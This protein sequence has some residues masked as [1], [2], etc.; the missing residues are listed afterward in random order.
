MDI[1]TTAGSH[2]GI[3]LIFIKDSISPSGQGGLSGLTNL[4]ANLIAYY[5]RDIDSVATA[6]P[7]VSMTLGQYVS[8]G[9]KEVDATH[10][11]GFYQFCPPI[12]VMA[13]GSQSCCIELQGAANMIPKTIEVKLTQVNLDLPLNVQLLDMQASIAALGRF[14]LVQDTDF[15]KF[16]FY[17]ALS[18]DGVSPATGLTITAQREIDGVLGNFKNSAIESAIEGWYLID[19]DRT[20]MQGV[21]II[22]D[23]SGPGANN[24]RL[25]VFPQQK[26]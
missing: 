3:W 2:P 4:S 23:F 24:C 15:Y 9:F 5:H 14:S 6:I 12:G 8:G 20:D 21:A 26:S 19:I 7:L 18:S 10:L 17:M 13:P 16:P 11:K 1:I 22:F 25:S